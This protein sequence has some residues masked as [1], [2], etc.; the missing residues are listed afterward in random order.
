MKL[1]QISILQHTSGMEMS[2]SHGAN[3]A[4]TTASLWIVTHW[5]LSREFPTDDI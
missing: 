5:L 2:T 4:F 1:L 3:V